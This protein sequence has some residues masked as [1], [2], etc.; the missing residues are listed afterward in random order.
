MKNL[1]SLKIKILLST[2]FIS[3]LLVSSVINEFVS[4]SGFTNLSSVEALAGDEN[5]T[6][7]P[8][9][10][11]NEGDCTK[12]FSIDADGYI[13]VFRKKIHVGGVSGSYDYTYRNVKID[14]PAGNTYYTCKECSCADFWAEKC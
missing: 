1:F 12:S 13:T 5:D 10:N 6:S 7:K 2:L 11:K 3:G 9:F 4:I 14:C 8:K